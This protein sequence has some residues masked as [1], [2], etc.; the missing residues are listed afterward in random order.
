[1]R[2]GGIGSTA[3]C[4]DFVRGGARRI[5]HSSALKNDKK[6][7][8]PGEARRT[9]PSLATGSESRLQILSSQSRTELRFSEAPN[10]SG[11]SSVFILVRTEQAG[12]D[13]IELQAPGKIMQEQ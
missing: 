3:S 2:E 12:M 4:V 5:V 10:Q 13:V 8:R 1:M 11:R 9:L 7:Q 6:L